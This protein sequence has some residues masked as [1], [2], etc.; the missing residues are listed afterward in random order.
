M[1]SVAAIVVLI[2]VLKPL[3]AVVVEG[4]PQYKDSFSINRCNLCSA[5]WYNN[6]N[7][8]RFMNSLG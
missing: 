3:V 2:L 4:T 8:R 1:L 5:K 6:F 7:Q